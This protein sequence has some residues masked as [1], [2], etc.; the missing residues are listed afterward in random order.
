MFKNNI[1]PLRITVSGEVKRPG[2]YIQS[3]SKATISSILDDAGGITPYGSL[4]SIYIERIKNLNTLKELL[5]DSLF[6]QN[7]YVGREK[8]YIP[9]TDSKKSIH[10][11]DND[12]L[13]IEPFKNVVEVTGEV[14]K[15]SIVD[16]KKGTVKDY[17]DKVGIS[18]TGSKRYSL[19]IYP[20]KEVFAVKKFLFFKS[21]PKVVAGSQIVVG[22]KP[23]RSKLTSQ[24]LIS[25]TSWLSTLVIVLSSLLSAN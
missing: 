24:E 12:K 14:L 5:N 17:L 16:F 19:V 1:L 8:I 25:A 23:E 22:Q 11:K 7:T 6:N 3:K 10:F 18:S 4:S 2:V 9:I 21:Y 15:P 20:N 13:V